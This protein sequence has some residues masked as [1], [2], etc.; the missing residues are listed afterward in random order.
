MGSI[1]VAEDPSRVNVPANSNIQAVWKLNELELQHNIS[2][3]A[4][5]HWQY[6]NSAYIFIGTRVSRKLDEI[7]L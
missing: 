2:G 1:A 7:A 5:W 6:R 4:S 3:E